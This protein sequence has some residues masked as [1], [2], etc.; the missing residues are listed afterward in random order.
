VRPRLWLPE[1]FREFVLARL[2]QDLLARFDVTIE[3]NNFNINL[4]LRRE[5]TKDE[6]EQLNRIVNG[7][8]SEFRHRLTSVK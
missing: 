3:D 4:E 6:L 5:P 1:A 2:P 7:A 8:T